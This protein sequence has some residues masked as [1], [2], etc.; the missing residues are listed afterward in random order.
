MLISVMD[1]SLN[2]PMNHNQM[3]L[4]PPAHLHSQSHNSHT[5]QHSQHSNQS[6]QSQQQQ[7]QGG[8]GQGVNV[9]D[10]FHQETGLDDA[11]DEDD[12]DGESLRLSS[13]PLPSC[14]KWSMV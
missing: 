13:F 9:D 8:N 14:F 5:S 7:G 1:P 3:N 6:N 2:Q 10:M 12:G 4:H 11:D